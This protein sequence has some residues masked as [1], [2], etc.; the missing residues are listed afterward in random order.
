AEHP[1]MHPGRC[2]RIEIDGFAIGFA[3][4]LRPKWRQAY[5]LPAAPLRFEL[6]AAALMQRALPAYTPVQRKQSVW[7]D[8]SVI[9]GESVTHEALMQT[10]AGAARAGL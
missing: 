5:E 4:E 3:G 10:I 8:L 6:D 2:A 1:A 7:R 9:A